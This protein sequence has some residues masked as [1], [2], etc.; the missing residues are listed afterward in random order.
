MFWVLG[1]SVY[2]VKLLVIGLI[3]SDEIV[4]QLLKDIAEKLMDGDEA[5][6]EQVDSAE[7][8]QTWREMVK[9]G[10]DESGYYDLAVFLFCMLN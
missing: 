2:H 8:W 7:H 1:T 4:L 6:T 9:E 10:M 3:I 5:V